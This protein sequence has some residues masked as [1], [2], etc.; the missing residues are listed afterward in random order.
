MWSFSL[1][2]GLIASADF[3]QTLDLR[4]YP[5]KDRHTLDL[6]CPVDTDSP[7]PVVLFV[8]GGTWMAGDKDFFGVNRKAGQMFARSGYVTAVMNYRLS[9]LVQHPEH[10]RDVARAFAWL[11]KN[12][13][14]YGGDPQRIV[15]VGH[16]AGGHLV[17]LV[18][19]DPSYLADPELKLEAEARK[20]LRGVVGVSGVYRI[21]TGSEFQK[22][23]ARDI[24][25]GWVEATRSPAVAGTLLHWA[26]PTI[27]PFRLVFGA[28]PEQ[29]RKASPIYQVRKGAPPFL[30]LYS[31]REPPTLDEMALDFARRLIDR[32]VPAEVR[33]FDGCNHRTIV[34]RLHDEKDV[35]SLKVLEF[36]RNR[37]K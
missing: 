32:G 29:I 10:A 18:A 30:L 25:E 26:S 23:M 17:S 12:V 15:L 27:N 19:T 36:V 8:H 33:A 28:D 21:P 3:Q 35:I 13:H 31:E 5:G 22:T 14:R 11:Q 7:A 6:F 4:Y 9:P 1:L 34:R 24:I 16:S 2:L 37:V 20:N